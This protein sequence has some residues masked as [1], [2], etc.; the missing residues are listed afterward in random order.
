MRDVGVAVIGGGQAGISLSYHLNKRR[1]DH[2][3]FERDRPF[4]SW[5]NRWNGF[6]ANTPNWMNTLSAFER[7]DVPSGDPDGFASKDEIVAYFDAC[8]EGS[9]LP[10]LEDT[11]VTR[12]EHIG[13]QR[14][15]IEAGGT[16]YSASAVAICNGAMSAPRLPSSAADLP[17][18]VVQL[19][20]SD[21]RSPEAIRTNNVLVV[22]GASSGVQIARLLCES[23]RFST[24][25]MA[26]SKVL[27]LPRHILG[28]PTH[29]AIY[30]LGLFDVRTTSYLGRL[31]YSGLETRGDPIMRPTARDLKEHYDVKLFAKYLGCDNR[32]I[33]FADGGRVSCD[34]LTVIWCTGFRPDYS[35]VSIENPDDAFYPSGHPKHLRGISASVPG[36]YFV[37]LRYQHTVASHDIYGVGN[38]AE[39][40]ADHIAQHL[41]PQDK[42]A[43]AHA[44][45]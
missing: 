6:R 7:R 9:N 19:H 22:G 8:L 37:G 33:R 24:I 28:I 5:R 42:S 39:F 27:V 2:L 18:D 32:M 29:R 10:I 44:Y 38:D 25:H 1:V 13:D 4:S 3:V 45:S 35:F 40:V 15:L 31:M 34:N 41:A 12:A 23:G 14:W 16:T 26:L 21:Y 17:S 30:R 43:N 11:Q 20:S 36:L